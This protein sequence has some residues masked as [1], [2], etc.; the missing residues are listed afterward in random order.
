M[1]WWQEQECHLLL[2]E[3]LN[4]GKTATIMTMLEQMVETRSLKEARGLTDDG[5]C[6]ICTQHS[7]TVEH[8]VAGCTKLANSEYLTR[9]NRALMILAVAGV[10]Q[11]ELGTVL[12]NDKVEL[13]W[14]FAFQLWKT[15]TVKRPDLILELKTDKKIWICYIA[16]LQQ[17]SIGVNRTERLTKYMQLPFETRERRP[18]C[19]IYMVPVVVRTLGSGIKVLKVNLKKIFDKNEL[20]DEVVAMMQ[21]TV[22][23]DSKS[24]VRRVMSDLIQGDDNE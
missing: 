19:E 22:L 6:R 12:E 1:Y 17:N 9:H 4:P 8:L 3:N 5:S 20:L 23:M 7:E 2:S 16:C 15:T 13:V 14:N 10:K 21:K 18:G 11:Q 24:M